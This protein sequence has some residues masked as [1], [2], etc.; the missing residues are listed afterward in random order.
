M[1]YDML[2][3]LHDIIK[4]NAQL[5]IGRW[6]FFTKLYE[7]SMYYNILKVAVIHPDVSS[8]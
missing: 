1:D 6:N 7:Y 5:Y 8:W 2:W 3:M 4:E